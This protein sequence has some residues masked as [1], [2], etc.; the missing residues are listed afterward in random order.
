MNDYFYCEIGKIFIKYQNDKKYYYKE[1]D[2]HFV[3]L[4]E[5]ETSIV[6]KLF[7]FEEDGVYY[8]F[9]LN[10]ALNA[11]NIANA[12]LVGLLLE[13]LEDMVGP[14][15]MPSLYRN[16]P[17]LKIKYGDCEPSKKTDRF[18]CLAKYYPHS[19]VINFNR[20]KFLIFEKF[21]G[22][23]I[24]YDKE[25][26][27]M[28]IITL[29]HELGHM[30]S[31]KYDHVHDV[32]LCGLDSYPALKESDKNRGI[33][34]GITEYIALSLFPNEIPLNASYYIEYCFSKQLS[35]LIGDKK[36][37]KSYFSNNLSVMTAELNKIINDRD[38]SYLLFRRMEDSFHLSNNNVRQSVL[39]GVQSDLVDYLI[40]KAE[41]MLKGG[42]SNKQITYLL[43]CF[44]NSLID[45]ELLPSSNKSPDNYDHLEDVCNKFYDF[46][47][48]I[49]QDID[50]SL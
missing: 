14:S 15:N 24:A 42:A 19:N 5:S 45:C 12:E 18:V 28:Y 33:T 48:Y 34:E 3:L 26:I 17:T 38:K 9:K 43:R 7:K 25:E 49:E 35:T 23:K 27:K 1:V 30:S 36:M 46:K 37:F 39:A 4:N 44:E 2:G 10:M 20:D 6:E 16:L 47:N 41:N 31:S 13:R 29:F 8:S 11:S 22:E 21:D 50:M 40:V 32:M